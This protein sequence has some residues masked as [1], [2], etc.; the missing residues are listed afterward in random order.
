MSGTRKSYDS[1]PHERDFGMST[2]GRGVPIHGR[3]RQGS[4]PLGIR[5]AQT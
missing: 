2:R 1:V 5:Q 4:D 3:R